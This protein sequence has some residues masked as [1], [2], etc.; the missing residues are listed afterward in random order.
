MDIGLKRETYNMPDNEVSMVHTM[1]RRA[2]ASIT[3]ITGLARRIIRARSGTRP[4]SPVPHVAL[5]LDGHVTESKRVLRVGGLGGLAAVDTPV[6]L[7][8]LHYCRRVAE[9]ERVLRVGG[10]AHL[11]IGHTP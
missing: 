6:R 8:A 2:S 1:S 5:D 10:L 3:C 9:S 4:S 11:A 7:V